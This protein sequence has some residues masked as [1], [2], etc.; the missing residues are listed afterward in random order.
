MDTVQHA[1]YPHE[2]GHLVDCEACESECFC[3]DDPGH[4]ECVFCSF[5]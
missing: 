1:N 5:G 4:T 3:D 2:F